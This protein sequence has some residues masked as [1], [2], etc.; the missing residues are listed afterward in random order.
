MV[1]MHMRIC[2][3]RQKIR[4]FLEKERA[5]IITL[6]TYMRLIYLSL[7]DWQVWLSEYIFVQFCKSTG[8]HR[9]VALSNCFLLF[10]FNNRGRMWFLVSAKVGYRLFGMYIFLPILLLLLFPPIISI[11]YRSCLNLRVCIFEEWR[12][13]TAVLCMWNCGY[14]ELGRQLI[15]IY[16]CTQ[17][18]MRIF[19]G[20]KPLLLHN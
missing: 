15:E 13:D 18:L 12:I 11:T 16:S 19:L 20:K 14:E 9:A 17:H 6:C 4:E 2:I 1:L 7:D 8:S 5:K 10:I 3:L